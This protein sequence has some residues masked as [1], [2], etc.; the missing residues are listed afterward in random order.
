MS[1]NN[2]PEKHHKVYFLVPSSSCLHSNSIYVICFFFHLIFTQILKIIGQCDVK[3]IMML[4]IK[5]I[6]SDLKVSTYI[7]TMSM[8]TESPLGLTA[9]LVLMSNVCLDLQNRHYSISIDQ[10]HDVLIDVVKVLMY[11]CII[12]IIKLIFWYVYFIGDIRYKNIWLK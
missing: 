8:I 3:H 2:A 12:I 7:I 11:K 6:T 9:I 1:F 5:T 10:S 4:P